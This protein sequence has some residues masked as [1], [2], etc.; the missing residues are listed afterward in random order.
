MSEQVHIFFNA[1]VFFTRIPCPKWVIHSPEYQRQAVIY[2]PLIGWIVGAIAALTLITVALILPLA[3]AIIL[4]MAVSVWIT[5]AFHEDGLG[6]VC[7]GFGGAWSADKTHTI[8]KD[9]RIGTFGA[10]GLIL[11]LLLKFVV[12]S[13]IGHIFTKTTESLIVLSAALVSGHAVSRLAAI[14]LILTH[15]YIGD[16]KASKS[17]LMA[18]SPG[19]G[20]FVFAVFCGLVPLLV[21]SGLGLSPV[22]F[23]LAP[24][25][26]IRWYLA[27]LFV[28][29][30]AGYTGDCLGA[31][32]QLTEVAF[33]LGVCA[34][35]AGQSALFEM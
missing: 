32:Q 17:V 29:R 31:A 6:D 8:M 9:S 28:R 22:W 5:G 2:A 16:D 12:L 3:I 25:F 24:V 4:S 11:V 10:V 20:R 13:E 23:A 34:M 30:L 33:Y 35:L 26:F 21:F 19:Q 27:R 7:D 14:S 18:T 1:V 15:R